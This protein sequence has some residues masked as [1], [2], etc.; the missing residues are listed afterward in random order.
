MSNKVVFVTG[1]GVGIGKSIAIEFAKAGYDVAASYYSSD[2]EILA[3]VDQIKAMGRKAVAIKFDVSSITQINEAF[4]CFNK[5]FDRLDVFVNNAGVTKTAPFL[6]TEENM[7]DL[8]CDVD[9]KGAYFCMQNAAK[10]MKEKEIKGSIVLI[11][12]NN[13]IAHFANA[14]VYGSV[15]A[16]ATKAAEHAAVELA[17]YGIRVNTIAPGWTDTKSDRMGD[18]NDTYYKIPL[19][20][21]ATPEEIANCA[22]FLSSDSAA[23]ITGATLVVDNGAL[24]VSDKREKYGF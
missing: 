19:N 10:I 13:Y 5:H 1:A 11:S 17:K 7:F 8:I 20:K 16:A 9:F 3:V 23:S 24:L 21:W 4:E 14:S 18:P 22:I 2:D 6:E 12:S 15:K